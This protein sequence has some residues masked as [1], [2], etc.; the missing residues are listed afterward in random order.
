[1]I[2]RYAG[3]K[4]KRYGVTYDGRDVELEFD[5][6]LVVLNRARLRV[7]GELVDKANIYYGD[8]ELTARVADGP[9]IAVTIY[10]GVI[11]ELARAQLRRADGSWVD[12][13]EREPLS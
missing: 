3:Y 6:K 10:S 8:K 1:M 4:T 2:D 5:K 13:E 7:D 11:G 9:E 12:L